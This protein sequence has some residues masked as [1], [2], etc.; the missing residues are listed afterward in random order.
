MKMFSMLLSFAFV[1]VVISL[2]GCAGSIPRQEASASEPAFAATAAKAEAAGPAGMEFVSVKGGCFRMGD[3]FGDGEPDEQP[4]HEVCVSDFLI[5]RHEVTQ[6]QWES[7]MG[8]NPSSRGDCGPDCPVESVSWEMVQEYIA[9]L[10]GATGRSYRLPTEAEWEYAARSGGKAERWAGTNDAASL[11][12][13]AWGDTI[14]REVGGRKANGLGIHDMTGNILEWCHDWYGATYYAVSPRD[15]PSGPKTGG[16]RVMRGGYA[17][18]F[19]VVKRNSD[20]PAVRDGMNG[21]RLVLPV[22]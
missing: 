17:G 1:V 22:R 8:S 14:V 21:F 6:R 9:K 7:V 2:F 16:Q 20:D 3:V 13:F 5:G 11:D 4:V 18:D 19:R 12:E 15:N 10:N